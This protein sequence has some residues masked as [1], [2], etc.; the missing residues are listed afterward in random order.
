M[1]LGPT[2]CLNNSL[3]RPVSGGTAQGSQREAHLVRAP[4]AHQQSASGGPSSQCR[5]E[6]PLLAL[7][8]ETSVV[9][10]AQVAVGPRHP[11]QEGF[12]TPAVLGGK[13][14]TTTVSDS[15]FVVPTRTR[16]ASLAGA[17]TMAARSVRHVA[18]GKC[19]PAVSNGSDV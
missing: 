13:S 15:V 2:W 19:T 14:T 8:P 12:R 6:E 7:C 5:R 9:P 16:A 11:G 3:A 18:E 1:A 10:F 4:G 17:P